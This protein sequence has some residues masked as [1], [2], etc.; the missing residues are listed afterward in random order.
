M[1]ARGPTAPLLT[2][3]AECDAVLR[4]VG[5]KVGNKA[6]RSVL[7]KGVRLAAKRIK[8][9]V[10]SRQKSV[11]KAI[12]GTVRKEKGGADKGIVKAKAGAAVGKSS[13]EPTGKGTKGGV[14]MAAANVHW[15][16]LGTKNRRVRKTGQRV[17][18]MPSHPI[19]KSAMAAAGGEI[20]SLMK[21]ELRPAIERETQK[22]ARRQLKKRG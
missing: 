10:P 21:R 13:T 9:Q 18:K 6:A 11:R 12:G 7:M 5:V 4:A 16:V 17:G 14:G 15:Y 1:R 20:V 3:V 8:A 19:V 22:E 2:G